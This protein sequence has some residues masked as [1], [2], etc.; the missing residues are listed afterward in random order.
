MSE[1]FNLQNYFSPL[2]CPTPCGYE[3]TKIFGNERLEECGNNYRKSVSIPLLVL[4]SS[5]LKDGAYVASY[6]YA[7]FGHCTP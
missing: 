2:H 6:E 5:V 4:N 7:P 1:N 3:F